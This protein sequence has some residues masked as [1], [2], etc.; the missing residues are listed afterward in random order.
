MSLILPFT[1]GS[2]FFQLRI[3]L[4]GVDYLFDWSWNARAGAWFLSL[5]SEDGTPLVGGVKVVSNRPLFARFSYLTGMPPGEIVAADFT[6]KVSY[7]GYDQL[8]TADLPVLYYTEAELEE[9]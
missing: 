5:A 4:E 3:P 8:G 2:A 7:P 9:I 6:R 1:R